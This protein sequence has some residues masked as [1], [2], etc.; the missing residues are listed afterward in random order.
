[1]LASLTRR[2]DS[3]GGGSAAASD[4]DRAEPQTEGLAARPRPAGTAGPG[5]AA[6]ACKCRGPGP[7]AAKAAASSRSWTQAGTPSHAWHGQARRSSSV[8]VTHV[9]RGAAAAYEFESSAAVRCPTAF[10]IIGL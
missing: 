4:S 6:A 10:L 2:A 9:S 7:T 8:T 1:M 5:P 3:P